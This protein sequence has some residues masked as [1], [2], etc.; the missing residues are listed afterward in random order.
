MVMP[1]TACF[2]LHFSFIFW[3]HVCCWNFVGNWFCELVV[4]CGG[5]A[6]YDDIFPCL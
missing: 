6:P 4:M 1:P 3:V 5:G 2:D